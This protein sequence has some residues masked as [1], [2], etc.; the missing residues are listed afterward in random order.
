MLDSRDAGYKM[1]VTNPP[2]NYA[3]FVVPGEPDQSQLMF[4]LQGDEIRIMP[5]DAPL[6]A[7]DIDLIRIW[8]ADG[9]KN[10]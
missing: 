7:A 2:D 8:I 9:A 6:P 1:L 3:P 5:P 10:N 4:L